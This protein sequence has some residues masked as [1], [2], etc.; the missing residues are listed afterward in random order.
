MKLILDLPV[1]A[2]VPSHEKK[3]HL[4]Y[5]RNCWFLNKSREI[6]HQKDQLKCFIPTFGQGI[7]SLHFRIEFSLNLKIRKTEIE[8]F[9][10]LR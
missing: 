7:L 4:I 8:M 1:I 3:K 9:N 5:I 6:N 10:E 2:C